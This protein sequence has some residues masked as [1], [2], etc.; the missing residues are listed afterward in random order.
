MA[1]KEL[2]GYTHFYYS[3]GYYVERQ[4]KTSFWV[5]IQIKMDHVINFTKIK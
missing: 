4:N 1:V 3:L 5:P 2:L